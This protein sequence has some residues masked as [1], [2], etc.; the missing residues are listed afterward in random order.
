MHAIFAL[1][2]SIALP[3]APFVQA[4]KTSIQD[5]TLTPDNNELYLT[6]I[7]DATTYT[8]VVSRRDGSSWT[9]PRPVSFSG[10]YRDLEEILSPDG[11]TM[12]FASSRPTSNDGKLIDGFWSG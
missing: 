6:Q 7:A 2:L 10:R 3:F 4:D 9:T 12:V 5:V 1:L 11:N 8:I